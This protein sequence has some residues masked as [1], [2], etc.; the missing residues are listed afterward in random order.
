MERKKFR[1][2]PKSHLRNRAHRV[3]CGIAYAMGLE[4]MTRRVNLVLAKLARSYELFS[5]RIGNVCRPVTRERFD[6]G[7]LNE[8][9]GVTAFARNGVNKT[10]RV[11]AV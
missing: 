7:E 11:L 3:I 9:E 4:N 10:R 1:Y 6:R 5:D 2:S 8:G